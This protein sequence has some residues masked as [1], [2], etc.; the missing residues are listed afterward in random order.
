MN[1]GIPNVFYGGI[2]SYAI[3][4][5]LAVSAISIYRYIQ[6]SIMYLLLYND[7]SMRLLLSRLKV[8]YVLRF[9]ADNDLLIT[10]LT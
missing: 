1:D 7:P 5:A 10:I 9:G 3:T 4:S 6:H 8:D 2:L